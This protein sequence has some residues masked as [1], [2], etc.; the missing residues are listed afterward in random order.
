M[1][2]V[3]PP[4]RQWSRHRISK[5]HHTAFEGS[6]ERT[7]ALLSSGFFDIDGRAEDRGYT[8]LM[9]AAGRGHSRVVRI[10]LNKGAD[11]SVVSYLDGTALHLSAFE[12]T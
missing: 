5:L 6:V 1:P 3:P 11:V 7:V 8:P 4:P 12:D 2:P 10:L 9:I